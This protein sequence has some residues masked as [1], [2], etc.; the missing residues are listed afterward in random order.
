MFIRDDNRGAR[1]RPP[2]KVIPALDRT[3]ELS[4]RA[5]KFLRKEAHDMT[6]TSGRLLPAAWPGVERDPW[7]GVERDPWHGVE[8]DPWHGVERDP[9]H[10]VET[11]TREGE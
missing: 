9:W 4:R 5:K 2:A 8:R 10:G 1:R 11:E 7:H 6:A 3:D